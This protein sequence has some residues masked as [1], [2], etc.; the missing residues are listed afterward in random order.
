ML[1]GVIGAGLTTWV[2][3]APCFLWIFALA[4][5]IER[6]EHAQRL[7]GALG[8]VTAAIVGVI[9]S[10]ALWFALHVMFAE[11][12]R[13]SFGPAALDVPVLASLDWRAALLAGLAAVLIFKARWSVLRVLPVVA[14]GGLAFGTLL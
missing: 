10:L 7:K 1:A 14:L 12:V 5:W 4:P 8:A 9:A 2:T 13:T 11:V 3:F 6:L